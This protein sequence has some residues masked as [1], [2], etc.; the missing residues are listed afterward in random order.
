MQ[1]VLFT[2]ITDQGETYMPF[3]TASLLISFHFFWDRS[4]S[5]SCLSSFFFYKFHTHTASFV[6][7]LVEA[8]SYPWHCP[9]GVGS[10]WWG[11]ALFHRCSVIFVAGVT[12]GGGWICNT[13]LHIGTISQHLWIPPSPSLHNKLWSRWLDGKSHGDFILC[14]HFFVT[15][16]ITVTFLLARWWKNTTVV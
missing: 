14:I 16:F 13:L 8:F 6:P 12:Q 7:P 3:T 10:K 4:V 2:L 15:Y 9:G 5:L 1:V 11:A